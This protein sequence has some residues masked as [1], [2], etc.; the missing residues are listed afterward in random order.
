MVDAAHCQCQEEA[1]YEST[2]VNEEQ[3]KEAAKV[4]IEEANRDTQVNRIDKSIKS[5][6]VCDKEEDPHEV[7]K[8]MEGRSKETLLLNP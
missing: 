4:D 6:M 3:V 8:T 5:N 7:A 2:K 1:K